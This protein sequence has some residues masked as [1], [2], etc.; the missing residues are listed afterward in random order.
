[1]NY[2]PFQHG[3]LTG[4]RI[5]SFA[6]APIIE[7]G[8]R[9]ASTKLFDRRASFCRLTRDSFY[10]LAKHRVAEKAAFPEA[11]ILWPVARALA[12]GYDGVLH[13]LIL[14]YCSKRD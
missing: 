1:M 14:S 13:V 7:E 3:K 8:R 6:C 11:V 5:A 12:G 10:P 9:S 4:R 2:P